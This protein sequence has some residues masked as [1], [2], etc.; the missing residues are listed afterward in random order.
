[1]CP[2]MCVHTCAPLFHFFNYS[3]KL[4]IS[5]EKNSCLSSAY[6]ELG[7]W[8][9]ISLRILLTYTHH[10]DH[11]RPL[12]AEEATAHRHE[13]PDKDSVC[14]WVST[15]LIQA[16]HPQWGEHFPFFFRQT[17]MWGGMHCELRPRFH[18][19]SLLPSYGGFC[20][21]KAFAS[22]LGCTFPFPVS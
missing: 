2:C 19:Y 4:I 1:M 18:S 6:N 12:G 16:G 13:E 8:Q 14:G 17:L 7:T 5:Y 3:M 20:T 10:K 11:S 22:S 9:S 21:S 15:H